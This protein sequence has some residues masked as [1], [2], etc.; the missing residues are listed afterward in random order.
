MRYLF[1]ILLFLAIV[2]TLVMLAMGSIFLEDEPW[3]AD[4]PA[5][6][7][8]DVRFTKEFVIQVRA[9]TNAIEPGADI[10]S[11]PLENLRGIMRLGARFLPGFRGDAA[12]EGSVVQGAA[13]VPIPWITGQKWLNVRAAAPAFEGRMVLQS[14]VVGGKALPPG[15]ALSLGRI[16]ANFAFGNRAGDTILESATSMKIE[17]QTMVFTLKLDEDG[18]G[19]VIQ[20]L[21][22]A[23]R[24]DD[25]PPP[26]EIDRY[27]A[28]IRQAMDAGILPTEGSYLPYI[29]FALEAALE[30][31]KSAEDLP[32]A[33]TAAL[34]GLAKACGAKDFSLIVGRLAGDPLKNF[35]EVEDL[36]R[37]CHLRWS[38]RH[39]PPFHHCCRDKGRQ[40]SRLRHFCW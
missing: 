15:L 25:M 33:Y 19:D 11:L 35:G 37:R 30:A 1:Q 12:I 4:M 39:T 22:G 14:A 13:S 28:M 36:L 17:G 6:T 32:N 38:H 16:V 24:G 7:S 34:F 23:L 5:P 29:R 2:G 3:L 9:A 8:E 40:Q 26:E 10:V 20:G 21:F 18:R 31:S 27:Y